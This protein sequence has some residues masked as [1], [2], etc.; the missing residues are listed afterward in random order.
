MTSEQKEIKK[1]KDVVA[2]QKE[3][4]KKQR[5]ILKAQHIFVRAIHKATKRDR[6]GVKIKFYCP[7]IGLK[8]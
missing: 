8:Q 1:L 6:D 3:V 2:K 5:K 7:K 4:L